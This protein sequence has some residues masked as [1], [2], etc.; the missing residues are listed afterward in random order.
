[1]QVWDP[2]NPEQNWSLFEN[3]LILSIKLSLS[4]FSEEI[5]KHVWMYF[6]FWHQEYSATI[7]KTKTK[8]PWDSTIKHVNYAK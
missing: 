1:M 3:L 2:Y 4:L 8:Y 5:T 7:H 6:N